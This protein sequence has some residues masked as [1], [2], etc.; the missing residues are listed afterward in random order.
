MKKKHLEPAAVL[1]LTYLSAI[2]IGTLLLKL[3]VSENEPLSWTDALF[4][5]TSAFTVTGLAVVDTGSEFTLFGELVIMLLIQMGGLGIMSFSVIVFVL[6]GKRIGI[7]QRLIVQQALGQLH[8]GGVV[9]LVRNLLLFSIA[10]E[11]IVACF[12][13]I[14]WVPQY[15]FAKGMYYSIFHAV[16]AFNNAGFGLWPDNMV[17]HADSLIVTIGITSLIILGGLGFT[18]L[19]DLSEHRSFWKWSLHTKIMMTATAGLNVF[20]FIMFYLLEHANNN[21]LGGLPLL[22]KLQ[23]SWFQAVTTRTAG[24]NSIDMG[25][26]N[27]QTAFFMMILMFIGAGSGST[28]GGIKLTTFIV[29]AAAMITYIQGKKDIHLFRRTIKPEYVMRVLSITMI[30]FFTVITGTFL[31]NVVEDLPFL[32]LMFEAMSAFATVGLSMNLTPILSDLGKCI[33]IVLMIMGKVG[34]LTIAYMLAKQ[35]DPHF[36]Y[37]SEDVLTG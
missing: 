14:D 30:A 6:L 1:L 4:T 16:S 3:P 24:F 18:V 29:M 10:I 5:A 31:M 20:A 12:L 8:F 25:A 35:R 11:L 23:A 21:T 7:K 36:K 15:G 34:P 37:P 33:L 17:Q 13:A 9:K 27:S 32:P 26:I 19:V 2:L 28:A 22:D